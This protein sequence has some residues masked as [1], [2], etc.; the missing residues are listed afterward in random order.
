VHDLVPF[1][2]LDLHCDLVRKRTAF[3]FFSSVDKSH[4]HAQVNSHT[5]YPVKSL[6]TL[7]SI[8]NI[9][10]GTTLSQDFGKQPM[11]R[12]DAYEVD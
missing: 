3:C 7:K 12:I 2:W 5:G 8:D 11:M 9:A 4:Q 10:L 6:T 1:R